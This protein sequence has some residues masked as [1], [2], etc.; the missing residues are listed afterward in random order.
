MRRGTANLEGRGP[1]VGRGGA[2]H[3]HGSS[4][5]GRQPWRSGRRAGR[6]VAS[7]LGCAAVLAA[8][9]MG[10]KYGFPGAK[11]GGPGAAG[12]TGRLARRQEPAGRAGRGGAE[13]RSPGTG[14]DPAAADA[15]PDACPDGLHRRGGG[16]VAPGPDGPPD[17]LPGL[18]LARPGRGHRRRCRIF[19]RFAVEPAPARWIEALRPLHDLLTASLADSEPNL[20]AAALDEVARLWVWLPGRSLTPA[21]ESSLVRWKEKIYRPVIRCLGNR[22]PRTLVA[23]VACL[24]SPADRQRRR[25]G[26]GLYRQHQLRRPQ[27]DHHLVRPPQPAADRRPAAASAC[28]TT[29]R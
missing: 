17:R 19:D 16:G 6:R 23:A 27:A 26:A 11:Q 21:E 4:L 3:E 15:D 7:I 18:Q 20:R 25:P 9:V 24:G 29:I 5:A 22:D 28:T 14:G 2:A 10:V 1:R 12:S 13:Q 8:I